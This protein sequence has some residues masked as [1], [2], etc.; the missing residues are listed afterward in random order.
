MSAQ[1]IGG[2]GQR[3]INVRD[4]AYR[5]LTDK[6]KLKVNEASSAVACPEERKFLGFS[7][8]K[9]RG[10]EAH[11]AESSRKV[12]DTGPGVHASD[13]GRTLTADCRAAAAIPARMAQLLRLLPDPR[14]AHEP[15]SM[16]TPKAAYVSLAAV[17]ERAQ[18]LQGTAPTSR[19]KF[20]AAVAA[21]SP[22]GFWRMSR[23]AT[24]QM[25]WP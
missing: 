2:R 18:S 11:R 15:R 12:P 3:D 22:T 25:A 14:C 23:H 21:G 4:R 1:T 24:I 10:R 7:I 8:S 9:R 20:Q 5:F 6:L 13:A 17:E 16:D 19:S